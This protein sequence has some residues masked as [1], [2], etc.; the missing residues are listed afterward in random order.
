MTSP[1]ASHDQPDQFLTVIEIAAL[2]RVS[3]ATVYRLLH[4]GRL[5]GMRVGKS[6][7][8]SRRAVE[9]YLHNSPIS[10]TRTESSRLPNPHR[11]STTQVGRTMR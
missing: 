5:P 4:A 10:S 11:A 9:D 1:D 6:M 3:R 8:V 2:L 7:R